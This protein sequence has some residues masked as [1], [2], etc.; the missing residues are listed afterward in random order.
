MSAQLIAAAVLLDGLAW[1]AACAEAGLASTTSYR[2]EEAVRAGRRGSAR[3]AAVAAD[4]TR[5]LNLALLRR[6]TAEMSAGV[7]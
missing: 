1:L 5:Y 6:V 3:L 4:P 2:A 7:L